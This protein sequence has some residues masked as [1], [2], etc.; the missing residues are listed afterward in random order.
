MGR[1]HGSQTKAAS[2]EPALVCSPAFR[3]PQRT[4]PPKAGTTCRAWLVGRVHGAWAKHRPTFAAFT[5]IEL[6]VVIAIIA[7]L[8]AMLLPA[9]SAAKERARRASCLNNAR[10]FILATHIYAGD[11]QEFLP[12]GD[13]DNRDKNDTHTPI[14]SSATKTNILRYIEPLR[15]LDCPN[16][17]RPFERQEGWRTHLDYGIAIG[18]HYMGGHLNTPW[19]PLGS[20]TNT[21]ISP[22]K[23]SDDPS[24]VLL[25]DLNVYCYS[26]PRILAPHTARGP[27][28]R[29]ES[30]FEQHLDSYE[31]TPRQVGAKGG[32][33]GKLDGSVAWKDISRMLSYRGSQLW[34]EGGAFGLW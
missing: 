22:Q 16:L 7:I 34:D 32:N 3:R 8:A 20:I 27:V 29:E 2:P 17:A 1:V 30:Y 11:N 19:P 33:V 18:Y 26:F 14:L 23:T 10:Q 4:G 28:V 25:A 24:L 21:W 5:L 9:L 13:T 12:R 15:V 31:Q 6:L